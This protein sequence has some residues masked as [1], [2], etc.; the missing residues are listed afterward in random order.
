VTTAGGGG[1]AGTRCQ[2]LRPALDASGATGIRLRVRCADGL[3]FKHIVRDDEDWNGAAFT[4]TFDTVPGG[5]LTEVDLPFE[6]AVPTKFARTLPGRVLD[7][8]RLTTF[9][10]VFSKFEFD[11]GLNPTF[12]EG[13]FSLEIDSIELY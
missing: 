13:P 12:R 6:S 9:Q 10:F 4:W 11:D 7:T 8:T 2:V 1:F 5:G 3:R